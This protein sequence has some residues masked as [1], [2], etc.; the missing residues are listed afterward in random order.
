[1]HGDL[2]VQ[3]M[4]W[5]CALQVGQMV[6]IF[7]LVACYRHTAIHTKTQAVPFFI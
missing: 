5:L 1:M 2:L 4:L 6:G 7:G 3:A